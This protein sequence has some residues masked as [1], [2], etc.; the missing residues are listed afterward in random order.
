M[1]TAL[2]KYIRTHSDTPNPALKWVEK[3]TNI[4]TNY[5]RMLSGAIT[6]ELLTLIAKMC[7]AKHILEIGCFTGFS[8]ICLAEGIEDENGAV[9]S[10]EINDELEELIL[11]GWEKAGVGHKAHLHIGDALESIEKFAREGYKFDMVYIDANK[12]EYLAYYRAVMP[13]LES[14]GVILADDTM[15]GGKVYDTPDTSDKQTRGLIEF[16]EFV[17]NDASVEVVMLPLRDGL[18]IIRK[19]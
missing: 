15:L 9:E 8:T 18:S 10:L 3:Q 17:K 13:L 6:G 14:G 16:N 2:D 11:S 19:K 4:K 1:E 12:R 5:P 7:G